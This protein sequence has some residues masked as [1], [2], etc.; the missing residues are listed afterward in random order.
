[1]KKNKHMNK[2]VPAPWIHETDWWVPE[3]TDW[4]GGTE[5]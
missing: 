4:E 1:M 2:M 5:K 3:E